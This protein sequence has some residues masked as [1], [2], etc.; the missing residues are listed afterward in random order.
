MVVSTRGWI[1][2]GP[3]PI[4]VRCGG[5]KEL[6]RLAGKKSFMMSFPVSGDPN[7]LSPSGR[8]FIRRGFLA[9]ASCKTSAAVI[10]PLLAFS[11]SIAQ[12]AGT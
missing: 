11:T 6:M 8:D 7:K 4:S 3:G 2:V 5:W 9:V 12:R 1:S 10:C